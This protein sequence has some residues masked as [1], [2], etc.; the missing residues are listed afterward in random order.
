LLG[1][2]S[3][4]G[5]LGFLF[6]IFWG[7]PGWQSKFDYWARVAQSS[8]GWLTP[9]ADIL[10]WP[11]FSP[12][13]GIISFAYLIVVS[14]LGRQE[15]VRS[16]VLT[17]LAW[18]SVTAVIL[19][20]IVVTGYG[21]IEIYIRT[22]IAKGVSGVPREGSPADSAKNGTDRPLYTDGPRV[23][24]QNQQRL[25][26]GMSDK[27]SDQLRQPLMITYMAT[28]M[29]AFSFASQLRT[30]FEHAAI[31]TLGPQEQP[32]GKAGLSGLIIE[33]DDIKSPAGIALQEALETM[34][35]Q[36]QLVAGP[37]P[38]NYPLVLFVGP[39]PVQP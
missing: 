11:Y 16:T 28:D 7:V 36:P 5:W 27:L 24:T 25:L 34:D 6:A 19:T 18:I 20:F 22:Q 32:L 12:T 26:I 15:A 38:G 39:R 21:G 9:L 2:F 1:Q 30:A 33:V 23:L 4:P 37:R 10:L 17:A 31:R 3:I 14:R 13:L 29:E 8:N 35:I